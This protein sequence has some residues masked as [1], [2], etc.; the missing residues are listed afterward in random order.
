[1]GRQ[2]P[3]LI[4]FVLAPMGSALYVDWGFGYA[5]TVGYPGTI[6]ALEAVWWPDLPL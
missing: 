2:G 3:H 5:P 6:G 1:M 4:T